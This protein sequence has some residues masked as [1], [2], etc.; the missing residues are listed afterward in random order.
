[1]SMEGKNE[2][3]LSFY[4]CPPNTLILAIKPLKEKRA[5]VRVYQWESGREGGHELITPE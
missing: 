1:M 4:N 5:V 3:P 2:C